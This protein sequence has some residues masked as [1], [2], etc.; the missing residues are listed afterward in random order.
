ME[1]KNS[2]KNTKSNLNDSSPQEP[3]VADTLSPPA[4]SNAAKMDNLNPFDPAALRLD[5]AEDFEVQKE[6]TVVSCKKPDR[7]MFYR[8]HPDEEYAAEVA[9]I[10]TG[11][12][13]GIYLVHPS[14]HRQLADEITAVRLFTTVDREDT[15]SLWPVKIG[16]NSWHVSALEAALLA[17]KRW[18]RVKSNTGAGR[19]ESFVAAGTSL[20]E[21]IWPEK[22]MGELLKLCFKDR[23]IEN[24][25]HPELKRLRGEV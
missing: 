25:D 8:T 2:Q 9:I 17:R 20:P 21:P 23:F 24:W 6:I 3:E 5:G 12:G 1:D 10:E 14:L 22:S 13:S 15:V 7:K 19:Y 18:V 4:D 11:I 16:D